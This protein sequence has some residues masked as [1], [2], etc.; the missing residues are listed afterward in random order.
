MVPT[1][2]DMLGALDG[3][4]RR[5]G[6][7][8]PHTTFTWAT[9]PPDVPYIVLVPGEGRFLYSDNRVDHRFRAYDVELY[10]RNY[11]LWLI[12]AVEDALMGAGIVFHT[13]EAIPD[14]LN[15]AFTLVRFST[16]L[17]EE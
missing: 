12:R 9:K 7:P 15:N 10:M 3:I 2:A 14:E 8:V 17:T 4:T 1:V 11:D 16:T 13:S 5:D 6:Q